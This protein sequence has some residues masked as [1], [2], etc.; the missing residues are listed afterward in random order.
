[1]NTKKS[2]PSDLSRRDFIS[3]STMTT[4][5]ISAMFYMPAA[6]AEGKTAKKTKVKTNFDSVKD[7]P[8]TKYSLPGL[9]PGKVSEVE[10]PGIWKDKNSVDPLLLREM[11]TRGMND[12]T[13]KKGTAAW[14]LFVEPSDIVGIKVNPVGG[15][16][17]SSRPE[18]VDI[19]IDEL[20]KAGVK[21]KNIVIWDR[22]INMLE[23][24]GYTNSRFP[25]IKLEGMQIMD[26][27]AGQTWKDKTGEHVSRKNFDESV[28]YW[29]DVEGTSDDAYL[30]QNIVSGKYSYFGKLVTEKLTKIINIPVLKNTGNGVSMATKNIGYGVI[31]NTKRLHVPLFFDVN[32]E[33]LG[34]PAVRDK[35]VLNILDGLKGQYEGG[36]MPNAKYV[37][38]ANKI[39][40]ATDPFAQDYI[41][42]LEML[43]KRKADPNVKVNNSPRYTDYLRYA[44]RVGL[45]IADPKKIKHSRI[46]L[47]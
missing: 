21:K 5:G 20:I 25:D 41:G 39:L 46:K 32:V 15:T 29:A 33:V 45:G 40:F 9:F 28:F 35:L 10:H 37:Y 11:M 43:K 4:A 22:C 24:A 36:P 27:K 2:R 42:Y 16:L 14:K 44:E 6:H 23:T 18:I 34:F 38:D 19:V 17:L 12:L 31:A 7:A 13:G 47:A 3:K 1:M 8:R 26:L 30:N